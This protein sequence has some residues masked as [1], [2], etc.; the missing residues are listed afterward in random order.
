ML[1]PLSTPGSGL[2][3]YNA[4]R[5]AQAVILPS[6]LYGSAV[7]T[8]NTASFTHL[9]SLWT[10][11][12]RWITNCFYSTNRNILFP[13][14]ALMPLESYCIQYQ[15]QFAKRIA[16]ASPK[17]NPVTARLPANFP[18]PDL[19]RTKNL[20]H[21]L[22]GKTNQPKLWN[23]G[24]R[25]RKTPLLPIDQLANILRNVTATL[26]PNVDHG[27]PF[28]TPSLDVKTEA[29]KHWL[30][31]HPPP[32]Y[33]SFE[34]STVPHLFMRL[35]KFISGRLYQFRSQKSYLACHQTWHNAHLYKR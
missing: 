20:R 21:L 19:Y 24:S 14:A 7:F 3:G 16:L 25:T 27:I 26:D 34:L 2:T 33:Y 1:K 23:H 4:R 5:L 30:A 15:L 22:R 13:E 9:N 10:R 8:P 29:V 12:L 31:S 18:T 32:N 11:V 6:L 35:D 28:V 17:R